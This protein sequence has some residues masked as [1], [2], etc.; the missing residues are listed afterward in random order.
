MLHAN[1]RHRNV[2]LRV[3]GDLPDVKGAGRVEYEYVIEVAA[4]PA[5]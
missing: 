3:V 1:V 2:I 4:Y 5:W